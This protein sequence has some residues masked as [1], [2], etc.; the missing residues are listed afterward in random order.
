MATSLVLVGV[1]SLVYHATLRQGAQFGDDISMLVLASSLLHALYTCPRSGASPSTTVS[2]LIAAALVGVVAS[3]T[4][5]Y[6]AH[7]N[8]LYHLLAFSAMVHSIWPRTLYLIHY[9]R[10]RRR[11]PRSSSEKRRLMGRFWRASGLLVGAFVIWNIDLEKCL[12]LRALRGRIGLP[13]AWMLELHGWWHVLTA[14]GADQ[15]V[16]LVRELSD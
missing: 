13:W 3:F 11:Q 1:T 15:Y 12:E 2:T 8:P 5:Y 9:H 14:M 6:I 7:P 4:A 10:G 16:Q